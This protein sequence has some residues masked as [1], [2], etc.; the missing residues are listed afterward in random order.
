[1]GFEGMCGDLARHV[2][3]PEFIIVWSLDDVNLVYG[4]FGFIGHEDRCFMRC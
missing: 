3:F 2:F 4:F 1:M